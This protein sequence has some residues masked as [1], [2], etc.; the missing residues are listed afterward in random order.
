MD[1]SPILPLYYRKSQ[2]LVGTNVTKAV[3]DTLG[4]TMLMYTELS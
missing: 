3:N 4:H 1:E 2:L